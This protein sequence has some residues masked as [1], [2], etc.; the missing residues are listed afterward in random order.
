VSEPDSIAGAIQRYL[1]SGEHEHDHPEWPGNLWDRAKKGHDDLLDALV[2]EV[3]RRADGRRHAPVPADLDLVT[4]TRGKLK[5]MVR[6][7]FHA[8]EHEAVLSLLEKSVVFLTA[9]TI[10]RVLR[11]QSWLHSAWDLA[12]LY[13]SSVDSELLGPKA[14]S[15]LGLSLARQPSG[16]AFEQAL[17]QLRSADPKMLCDISEDP[18]KC[19]K[20]EG[21][22]LRHRDVVLP[23]LG[24]RQAQVTAGLT[25]HGVPQGGQRPN[26]VRPRQVS[27]DPH[28]ASSSSRTKCRRTTLGA[29]PSSKWQRTASRISSCN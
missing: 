8:A 28:T 9:D 2:T 20:T 16:R 17:H 24:G 29:C 10:E 19:P 25:R 13:L 6:G 4:W 3:R 12:N 14:P 1:R 26:E 27:R 5:P 7:L 11:D 22:M 18:G 23:S 21:V 15:L